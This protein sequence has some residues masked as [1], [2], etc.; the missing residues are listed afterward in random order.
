[1]PLT[2]SHWMIDMVTDPIATSSFSADYVTSSSALSSHHP[3]NN[4][5][6]HDWIGLSN[7]YC[8]DYPFGL[9]WLGEC[10]GILYTCRIGQM[11]Q[12]KTTRVHTGCGEL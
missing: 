8:P 7:G 10:F 1:M 6:S 9:Q 3:S 5:S 11:T 4:E 12:L 2:E